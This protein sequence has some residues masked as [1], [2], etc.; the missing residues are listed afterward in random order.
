MPTFTLLNRVLLT[1]FHKEASAAEIAASGPSGDK[2]R[3]PVR[4]IAVIA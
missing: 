2:R 1:S 3:N 4:A